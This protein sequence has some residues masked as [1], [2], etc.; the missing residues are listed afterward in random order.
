MA[1][2]SRLQQDKTEAMLQTMTQ[3][4]ARSMGSMLLRFEDRVEEK[5]RQEIRASLRSGHEGCEV[6]GGHVQ[7]VSHAGILSADAICIYLYLCICKLLVSEA[8]SY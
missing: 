3:T 6:G 1:D 7:S 4:V 2:T 8:L 5:L